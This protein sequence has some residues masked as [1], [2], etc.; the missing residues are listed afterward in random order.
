MENLLKIANEKIEKVLQNY[1]NIKL[2][3]TELVEENYVVFTLRVALKNIGQ[4]FFCKYEEDGR[5]YK[6]E[7]NRWRKNDNF[8]NYDSIIKYTVD[9][10]LGEFADFEC[11]FENSDAY[12]VKV[13]YAGEDINDNDVVSR[14]EYTLEIGFEVK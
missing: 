12:D 9:T 2:L 13:Y 5:Y 8:L 6:Y 1:K 10:Y 3:K 14:Y 7:S 11:D 4:D